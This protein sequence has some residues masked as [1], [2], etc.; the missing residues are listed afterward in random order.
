MKSKAAKSESHLY[1]IESYKTRPPLPPVAPFPPASYTLYIYKYIYTY[2]SPDARLF[3]VFLFLFTSALFL[4]RGP[5]IYTRT[6]RPLRPLVLTRQLLA[7]IWVSKDRHTSRRLF[8]WDLISRKPLRQFEM[9]LEVRDLATVSSWWSKSKNLFW[10]GGGRDEARQDPIILW[11]RLRIVGR[12]GMTR[13]SE[14]CDYVSGS[15]RAS[16]R[17]DWSRAPRI[18]IP[19]SS[20]VT[21]YWISAAHARVLTEL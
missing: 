8:T 12:V 7:R 10:L 6:R 5:C 21:W 3:T 19:S 14:V 11:A 20:F 1:I 9:I 16:R 15:A 2:I 17:Y 18:G 13:R 4:K